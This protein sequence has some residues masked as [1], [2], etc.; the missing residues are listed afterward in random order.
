MQ[1]SEC[2]THGPVTRDDKSP[3]ALIN[4][5]YKN[6]GVLT[7][8]HMVITKSEIPGHVEFTFWKYGRQAIH[9]I[10]EKMYTL[11]FISLSE[12]KQKTRRFISPRSYNENKDRGEETISPGTWAL[13]R[14]DS[15]YQGASAG[16]GPEG[17][18]RN[19][20]ESCILWRSE[21]AVPSIWG[22]ESKQLSSPACLCVSEEKEGQTP[23]TH[24]LF[25]KA[26]Q[27]TQAGFSFARVKSQAPKYSGNTL[28]S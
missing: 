21:L 28:G 5:S 26:L 1:D 15:K 8:Q 12:E 16:R 9:W 17:S 7:P 23:K 4:S 25:L 22:W 18:R 14:K 6:Y 10:N 13:R 11:H 27:C 24:S 20:R 3:R 2:T 19:S